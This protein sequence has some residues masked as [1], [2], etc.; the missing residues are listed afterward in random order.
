M[1]EKRKKK[2]TYEISSQ[3]G[4]LSVLRL[5]YSIYCQNSRGGLHPNINSGMIPYIASQVSNA[6]MTQNPNSTKLNTL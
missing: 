1:F 4:N 6:F 2:F 3:S 5:Q